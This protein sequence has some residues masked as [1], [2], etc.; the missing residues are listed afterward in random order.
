MVGFASQASSAQTEE[1]AVV[2]GELMVATADVGGAAVGTAVRL[3]RIE[4]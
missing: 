1:G 2:T 3:C 4:L